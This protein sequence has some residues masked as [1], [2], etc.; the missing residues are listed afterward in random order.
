MLDFDFDGIDEML[1]SDDKSVIAYGKKRKA[2]KTHQKTEK[3]KSKSH[4]DGGPEH[5]DVSGLSVEDAKAVI[6][7]YCK[8]RKA[9][10]DSLRA[11]R[12]QDGDV[13]NAHPHTGVCCDI[14]PAAM[15]L[16]CTV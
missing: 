15:Y 14:Q 2:T 3:R 11:K 5:P 1:D 6:S 16:S 13:V 9:F 10:T 12:I 4:N 8:D 7:R